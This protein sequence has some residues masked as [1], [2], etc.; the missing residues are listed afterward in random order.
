MKKFLIPRITTTIS[1]SIRGKS[2]EL[3][4]NKELYKTNPDLVHDEIMNQY[5][6]Y[7]KLNK[8][9]K[10][11]LFN[12]PKLYGRLS[13]QR[14]PSD[15]RRQRAEDE[16]RAIDR[17]IAKAFCDWFMWANAAHKP[18]SSKKGRK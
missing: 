16:R 10:T 7:V 5:D 1:H 13:E 4:F 6:N 18:S 12:H 15:I 14:K 3:M 9:D 17:N 2:A 8:I 11:L